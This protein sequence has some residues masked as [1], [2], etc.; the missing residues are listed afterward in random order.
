MQI[1]SNISYILG[2]SGESRVLFGLV[3]YNDLC[4]GHPQFVVYFID[5]GFNRRPTLSNNETS[6]LYL[7]PTNHKLFMLVAQSDRVR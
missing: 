7:Q 6:Y 5:G 4:F 1:Y 3:S 2:I